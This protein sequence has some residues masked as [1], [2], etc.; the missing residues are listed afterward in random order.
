[1]NDEERKTI[2]ASTAMKEFSEEAVRGFQEANSKLDRLAGIMMQIAF[3]L[4]GLSAARVT[5]T[6][7]TDLPYTFLAII[8]LASSVFFV[9]I[10]FIVDYFHFLK[11]GA[12]RR[13]LASKSFSLL[14]TPTLENAQALRKDL[15]SVAKLSSRSNLFS[16]YLQ[17]ILVIVSVFLIMFE[18]RK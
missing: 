6:Q 11:E 16:L 3:A 13:D 2:F 7:N 14:L 4:A 1:M 18:L 9:C 5:T 12:T 10:Q 17:I 8:F 15:D